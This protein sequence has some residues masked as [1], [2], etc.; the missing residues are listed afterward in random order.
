MCCLETIEPTS[1]ENRKLTRNSKYP[2]PLIQ[3]YLSKIRPTS[4]LFPLNTRQHINQRN[5]HSTYSTSTLLPHFDR[6][7]IQSI[8]SIFT[9]TISNTRCLANSIPST[10]HSHPLYLVDSD[11]YIAP[12]PTSCFEPTIAKLIRL[13]SPSSKHH[14]PPISTQHISISSSVLH[15]QSTIISLI[16][17][18]GT[19]S[20]P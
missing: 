2:A 7:C 10:H 4:P 19:S 8:H 1:S 18:F 14:L 17:C 5:R 12:W 16:S 20:A 9:T 13:S 15:Q 3:P 6:A 11:Y